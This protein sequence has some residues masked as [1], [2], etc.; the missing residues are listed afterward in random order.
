MSGGFSSDSSPENMERVAAAKRNNPDKTPVVRK[1]TNFGIMTQEGM[2]EYPLLAPQPDA[3]PL[4]RATVVGIS[5]MEKMPVQ[6]VINAVE[7]ERLLEEKGG[8]R[9]LNDLIGVISNRPPDE[10]LAR[11][12]TRLAKVGKNQ[13]DELLTRF[14]E[15]EADIDSE[16]GTVILRDLVERGA[17]RLGVA[18]EQVRAQV[19]HSSTEALVKALTKMIEREDVWD[20]RFRG[21]ARVENGMLTRIMY[22]PNLGEP[23]SKSYIER[24][25]HPYNP[26]NEFDVECC[27]GIHCVARTMSYS[28]D[29]PDTRAEPATSFAALLPPG[30]MEEYKRSRV[31]PER[32]YPC[33]KCALFVALF[34]FVRAMKR[35]IFWPIAFHNFNVVV[36]DK[37]IEGFPSFCL[38]PLT[39]APNNARATGFY[40]PFPQI[41]MLRFVPVTAEQ[42]MFPGEEKIVVPDFPSPS[43][44]TR[45]E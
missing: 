13:H 35:R 7:E 41:N 6:D 3:S 43:V 39:D 22:A 2:K 1:T 23:L 37:G 40:G 29:P 36:D 16:R 42:A 15:D 33:F 11:A 10:E 44:V 25:L 4:E 32:K 27:R 24:Y 21:G 38:F 8:A 9:D 18:E 28:G 45:M 31:A 30:V 5:V 19:G 26:S 14:Q 20:Q 34:M 12:A 17:M